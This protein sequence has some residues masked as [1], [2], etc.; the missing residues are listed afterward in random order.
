MA[1]AAAP[2]A[3]RG[4][5]RARTAVIRLARGTACWWAT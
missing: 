5:A 4:C 2:A 1:L 3:A